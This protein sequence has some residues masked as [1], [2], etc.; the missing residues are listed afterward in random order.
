MPPPPGPIRP[1]VAVVICAF[2]ERRWPILER[3]VAETI[4]QLR[5]GDELVVVI[6]HNSTL[7]GR[8]RDAWA[9][10]NRVHVLP[11]GG[12][13]GLSGGRN[14]GIEHSSAAV[15][16]FLD[17]DAVPRAGWLDALGARFAEPVVAGVGG[18]VLPR[19]EVGAAPR[20]FP[21]EFTWV[22]GCDYRGLPED[23]API[24]NPI[25]ANMAIAR[26]AFEAAGGFSERLGRTGELPTGCEETEL[27][28]RIR[29]ELPGRSVLRDTSAVVDHLVP[30][31]RG[32]LRYLVRRCWN[33]GR[34][35]AALSSLVGSGAA[36]ASERGHALRLVTHAPARYLA[37]AATGDLGGLARAGCC[38]LGLAVT[39]AGYLSG[40]LRGVASV[41]GG[42]DDSL[43]AST[44]APFTPIPLIDIDLASGD[45]PHSRPLGEVQVLVRSHGW[46]LGQTRVRCDAALE[47]LSGWRAAV[48]AVDPALAASAERAAPPDAPP[49]A[50][51]DTVSVV[52]CTLGR[53][54]VL[55]DT[56]RAVLRQ[57]GP[58]DELLV[59]DNNP[60][61]GGVAGLLA[62]IDD[63]RL[64]VVD[65]PRRGRPAPATP[66]RGTLPEPCSPLPTTTRCPI[67]TGPCS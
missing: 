29:A 1:G 45:T 44:A 64:R 21:D 2:D 54:P 33:E 56:V 26:D 9:S 15:V 37:Q 66:G 38:L 28:I 13:R 31:A 24:R 8:A 27:G 47:D 4:D 46:P 48:A 16:A 62:G 3:A 34:S 40:R 36:L 63:P 58:M 35:K 61:S 49:P 43:P 41:V 22:V 25:G 42:A 19:W 65:E 7:L 14:T 17:D 11:N 18:A 59:V 10:C 55:A 67:R 20:W 12:G 53:N 52:V 51:S 39:G 23:G 60:G 6:D 30:A 5:D 32:T 50:E 57:R